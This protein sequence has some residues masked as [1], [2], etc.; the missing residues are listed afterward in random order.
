MVQLCRRK[1]ALQRGL[2]E[3]KTFFEEAGKGNPQYQ[4]LD[5]N[6]LYAQGFQDMELKPDEI[7]EGE[8]DKIIQTWPNC[9]IT[10]LS[11]IQKARTATAAPTRTAYTPRP[12]I[13]H[14]EIYRNYFKLE[15]RAV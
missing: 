12:R 1:Q 15:S 4:L 13:K 3:E 2:E 11:E 5:I 14:Q 9:L 10:A 8:T 7:M 6:D